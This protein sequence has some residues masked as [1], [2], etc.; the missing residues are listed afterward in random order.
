MKHT[1]YYLLFAL[2]FIFSCNTK[3]PFEQLQLKDGD[4]LAY[5]YQ[6]FDTLVKANKPNATANIV[7]KKLLLN[8]SLP[9]LNKLVDSIFESQLIDCFLYTDTPSVTTTKN[10]MAIYIADYLSTVKDNDYS[11]NWEQDISTNI[12][13]RYRHI[14]NLGLNNYNYSGG[15]HPNSH[16]NY[17]LINLNTL[18]AINIKDVLDITNKDLLA[19]GKKR[20]AAINIEVVKNSGNTDAMSIYFEGNDKHA[21]GEFYFN[22]NWFI[23]GD[24]MGCYYNS[25]EI[26]PYVAGPSS[27]IFSIKEL[28][29]Y[30]KL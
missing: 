19:L 2:F 11:N 17:N 21:E 28:L 20:F 8:S 16:I 9:Q 15:A 27:C 5:A 13:G 4:T 22:D 30:L 12:N 25:Y 1:N 14:L 7:C 10:A 3:T 29:P 6:S 23:K 24:S 26:A 18:K